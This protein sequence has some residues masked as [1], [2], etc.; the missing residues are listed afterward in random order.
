MFVI[1]FE[2]W[3]DVQWP[4]RKFRDLQLQYMRVLSVKYPHMSPEDKKALCEL[5]VFEAARRY[6]WSLQGLKDR[7]RSF[8]VEKFRLIEQL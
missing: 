6:I 8:G 3:G 2:V 7:E 1:I 4:M 5:T